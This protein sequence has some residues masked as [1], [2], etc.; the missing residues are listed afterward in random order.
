MRWIRT[1]KFKIVSLAVV[2]GVLSAVATAELLLRTT[3]NDV[4]TLL[5]DSGASEQQGTATLLATKLQLLQTTVRA[6]AQAVRPELWQDTAAL[7]R[8]LRQESSAN[9]LFGMML[10]ADAQGR[11]QVRLINGEPTTELPPIGDRPYFQRAIGSDQ[12]VISEPIIGRASERPLVILAMATPRRDGHPTG[13]VAGTLDL[14]SA[15]LFSDIGLTDARDGSRTL[16]LD[17]SGIVLAHPDPARVMGNAADEPGLAAVYRNWRNAGSPID[18]QGR[19]MLSSGYLISMAGIPVSDWMLVHLRPQQVALRPLHAAQRAAWMS[20]AAV[21]LVAALLATWFGLRVTRPIDKLRDRAIASLT[22]ARSNL[23]PWPAKWG[24]ELGELARVF[25]H[26]EDER[27]RRERDTRALLQQLEAVLDHAQVGIALT[28]DGRFELVS[29]HFCDTFG[30]RK[31]EMEGKPTRMIYPSDEAFAALAESARPQFMEQGFFSGEVELKRKSGESFWARMRG[32]AVVAGDLSK[33][34]IWTFEDV[35]EMRAQREQLTWDSSHDALTGLVNRAAFET[36]LTEATAQAE[37][38]AFCA[39]FIDLDRFKQ[40][41]DTGGHAAGD[42]VLRDIAER[43]T[44][45]VRKSDT[46]AR[47][48]GDEFAVL[49]PRCPIGH[50]R[51]IAE[52]I[53]KTVVDYRLDRE[54][55]TF[56]IGA[57]I[58]VVRVD[59]SFDSAKEVLS[60]ADNA[61]YAAKHRGRNCV[62]VYGD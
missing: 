20:A 22:D 61:C 57:S 39:L 6:V 60:A 55:H 44:A 23:A 46:V 56:A 34:T 32:R 7:Q 17:R 53:R 51:D 43:L 33:G 35:T 28:R 21:G 31:D 40:V 29:R 10:A 41:N 27:E 62:V 26:V 19:A 4:E 14:A 30:M 50:A 58:G 45:Q 3:R 18:T 38:E 52:K 59:G 8:H 48:G 2:M 25:Q 13:I 42:A 47:L 15:R 36:L 24:G 37:A 5:L 9:A 1:L 12:V 11:L 49:L 54:G 16:V